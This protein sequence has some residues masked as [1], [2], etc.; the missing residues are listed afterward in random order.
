MR[1][2]SGSVFGLDRTS[3]III[4]TNYVFNKLDVFIVC[5]LK[6]YADIKSSRPSLTTISGFP[7]YLDYPILFISRY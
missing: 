7:F 2:V 5:A 3:T 6:T 4:G 1:S